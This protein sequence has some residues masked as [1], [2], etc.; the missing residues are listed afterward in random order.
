[1]K[2]LF[3]LC[4]GNWIGVFEIILIYCLVVCADDAKSS[5][6]DWCFYVLDGILRMWL[7]YVGVVENRLTIKRKALSVLT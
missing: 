2:L 4:F 7:V 3:L 6:L 1:V 5:H